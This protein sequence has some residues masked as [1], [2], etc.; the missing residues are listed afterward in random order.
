MVRLQA[1]GMVVDR[2]AVTC[3]A[4][5]SHVTAERSKAVSTRN[6]IWFEQEATERTEVWFAL[7][8]PFPPVQ[9]VFI[10]VQTDK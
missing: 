8:P 6:P 9:V 10:A 5:A 4:F 1:N 2:S 7:L 3:N